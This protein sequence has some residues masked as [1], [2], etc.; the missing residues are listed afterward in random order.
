MNSLNGYVGNHVSVFLTI[1]GHDH[2]SMLKG[3]VQ[4][5]EGHMLHLIEVEASWCGRNIHEASVNTTASNVVMVALTGHDR[6]G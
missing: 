1:P 4:A 2:L 6:N 3:R 5:V